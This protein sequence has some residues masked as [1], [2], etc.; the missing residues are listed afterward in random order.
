MSSFIEKIDGDWTL[1]TLNANDI[2]TIDSVTTS[3]TGNLVVGNLN[4]SGQLYANGNI[5]TESY[6]IGN[7]LGNIVGN[8]VVPGANTDVLF[9]LNGNAWAASGLTFD[10]ASNVLTSGNAISAVG[11]ITAGNV[12]TVG[13]V[14]ANYLIGNGAFI[15]GLPDAY[16]NANVENYLPIYT[17]NLVSLQGDVI[18]TANVSGNYILGNG[19]FLT[20][21]ITSVANINS[22]NSNVTVVSPGG[23]ITVGVGGTSNVVVFA[24]T[25]EYVTGVVSAS[26]NITG[27]NVI[28]TTSGTFGNIKITGN[29][30]DQTQANSII[31]I[32][33]CLVNCISNSNVCCFNSCVSVCCL[34]IYKTC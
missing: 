32:N 7:F 18:T 17:G 5:T 34:T 25:G 3:V 30:I 29:E 2:V 13:N 6:F 4:T 28:G 27:P 8:L 15:T 9:N 12:Y 31:N 14:T 24:T 21:V 11:T 33:V 1:Q 23:N 22:G 20:G 19:Y 26:G 10:S 16:S